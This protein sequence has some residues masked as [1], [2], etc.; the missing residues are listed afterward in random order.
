MKMTQLGFYLRQIRFE[1]GELLVDMARKLNTVPSDLSKVEMGSMKMPPGWKDILVREY[2]LDSEQ[3]R[4]LDS[5]IESQC[6]DKYTYVLMQERYDV[7][8]LEV[9]CTKPIYVS[10][11][12]NKILRYVDLHK[13]D[14]GIRLYI[15]NSFM[16]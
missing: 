9:L 3:T 8:T 13:N 15:E 10:H 1:N 6:D 7:D 14:K 4:L 16:I 5:L 2:C 12:K 11:D